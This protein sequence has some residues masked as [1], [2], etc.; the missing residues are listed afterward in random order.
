[1]P[2]REMHGQKESRK[3]GNPKAEQAYEGCVQKLHRLQGEI[4]N[5]STKPPDML[6]LQMGYKP[7][8]KQMHMG[9]GV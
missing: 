1:M 7:E 2:S 8:R 5:D 4:K 9:E 6:G 3:N